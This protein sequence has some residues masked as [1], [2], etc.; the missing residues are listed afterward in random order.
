MKSFKSLLVSFRR[1]NFSFFLILIS[2]LFFS[3][4]A[5]STA[6][7]INNGSVPKATKMVVILA[8]N[9][10]YRLDNLPYIA[11]LRAELSSQ[12]D[13][14]VILL[15]AGDVLFPSLLSRRYNGAQMIDVLN[16][17]DGKQ[18][19]FDEKML[20]VFG[21]HEFDKSKMKHAPMLNQRLNE[22][23]FRWLNTNIRF[24][25]MISSPQLSNTAIINIEGVNIGFI[26]ST[27]SSK[28]A[29]YIKSFSDPI[30]TFKK[31]YRSLKR[32]GA[33]VVIGLTHHNV[34][35]DK[36][37][38]QAMGAD[39][40][41]L[42]VGGHEH[43]KQK[44]SRDGGLIVKADADALTASVIEMY[45][46][47]TT[48]ELLKTSHDFV[49]LPG[50]LP[51]QATV[52]N[53]IEQWRTKFDSEM[54]AQLEMESGCLNTTL[55]KASVPLV[56]EE[57]QIRRFETNL[58]NFVT[59]TARKAFKDADVAFINSGSLRLNYTIAAGENVTM[60]HIQTLFAYPA[61]LVKL[62]LDGK[63][64][65]QVL[66]HSVSD[67]SGNG[68]WLQVS[69]IAFDHNV[70]SGLAKHIHVYR[71][72]RYEPLND[73]DEIVAITNSYLVDSSGDQDG[74]TMLSNSQIVS[75]GQ[76]NVP[77][78][79]DLVITEMKQTTSLAPKLEGRICNR[80]FSTPCLLDNLK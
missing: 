68:H 58:G 4:F 80:Q 20:V 51:A 46:D 29:D 47:N 16:L 61:K 66:N 32:Q 15:H 48:N 31:Q 44:F 12:Y 33:D 72:G 77:D 53:R 69:G 54:C 17:L 57:L 1:F 41:P 6:N 79:K 10:V 35:D 40:I 78:L 11:T 7:T 34:E 64:L 59:D 37:L 50:T 73:T 65:K 36:R 25:D 18:E 28:N 60:K 45:F 49:Q 14:D 76:Q 42:I 3:S 55:T 52:A 5:F 8:V 30:E 70:A 9:D 56:A 67:W 21:N 74:Y 63:T 2:S 38:L 62:R 23:Q 71:N 75:T 27:I 22:S 39:K 19:T 26:G 43:H 13:Q 24:D